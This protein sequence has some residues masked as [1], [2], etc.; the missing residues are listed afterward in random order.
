MLAFINPSENATQTFAIIA[1]ALF[2]LAVLVVLV[3][4]ADVVLRGVLVAAGA[5]LLALAVLFL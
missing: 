5:A 1:A 2:V 4:P 3:R